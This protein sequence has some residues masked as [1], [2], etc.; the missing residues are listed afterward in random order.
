MELLSGMIA[1]KIVER[2]VSTE[3]TW[4]EIDSIRKKDYILE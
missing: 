3:Q 4:Q 2:L 1:D